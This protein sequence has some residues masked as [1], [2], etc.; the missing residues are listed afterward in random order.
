[1]KKLVKYLYKKIMCMVNPVKFYKKEGVKIGKGTKIYA[2]EPNMFSS[3]PWVVTIGHNC[4]ITAGC[5]F[6]THDGGTLIFDKDKIDNFVLVGNITV[7]NN[8]YFGLRSI[9]MGGDNRK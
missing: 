3:E 6:L 7:G 9:V 5:R 2:R 1:M 8:V 4:H